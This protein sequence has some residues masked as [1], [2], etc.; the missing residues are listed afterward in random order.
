MLNS[1]AARLSQQRRNFLQETDRN[2]H[3][4][5]QAPQSVAPAKVRTRRYQAAD[6]PCI[7]GGRRKRYFDAA[8][9]FSSIL[10]WLPLLCLI[11]IA[12]KFADR[13]PILYQHRRV[14]RNGETFNMYK[15]RTMY[16][17]AD[18]GGFKTE[19]E[20]RRLRR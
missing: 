2:S 16:S 1:L 13:G 5:A 18:S 6:P 10:F 3:V 19:K 4:R 14:G 7:V 15:L 8:A 11:A 20:D 9:A 12:V 17:G